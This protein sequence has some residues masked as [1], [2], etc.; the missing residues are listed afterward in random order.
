MFPFVINQN[1]KTSLL[2]DFAIM[3]VLN[4]KA[5]GLQALVGLTWAMQERFPMSPSGFR[6]SRET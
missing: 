4:K 3:P 5:R 1:E 2:L 6:E